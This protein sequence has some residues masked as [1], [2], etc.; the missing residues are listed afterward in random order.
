V[1]DPIVII[2]VIIIALLLLLCLCASWEG[3]HKSTGK[4]ATQLLLFPIAAGD[5][6]T[7]TPTSL[8]HDN[9]PSARTIT[10]TA[11]LILP[12]LLTLPPS[13]KSHEDKGAG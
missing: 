7:S 8:N 12:P 2:V 4:A 10:I 6:D 3:T 5:N 13:I 9:P 11:V 1:D